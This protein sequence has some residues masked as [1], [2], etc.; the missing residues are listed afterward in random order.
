MHF[1]STCA[2]SCM[3]P[4][5]PMAGSSVGDRWGH[6]T[7]L[8]PFCPH[9]GRLGVGG[10]GGIFVSQNASR[11]E[12]NIGRLHRLLFYIERVHK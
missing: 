2:S 5:N 7:F 9:M 11:P 12:G 6:Y 10:E 3:T 4:R 8:L 1:F